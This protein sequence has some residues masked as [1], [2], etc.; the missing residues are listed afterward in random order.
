MGWIF[1]TQHIRGVECLAYT[2]CAC[3]P[4]HLLADTSI[5]ENIAFGV[6]PEEIDLGRVK[7][8]ECVQIA[9]FI[10]TICV[11]QLCGR[12]RCLPRGG[13]RQRIGIAR[14]PIRPRCWCLMKPPVH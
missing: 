12:T 8:A 1:A 10:E 14:A 9:S 7:E 2:D 3:S 6:P 4:N 5:A 11:W 13:Q